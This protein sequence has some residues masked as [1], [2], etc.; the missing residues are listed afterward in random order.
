MDY[1]QYIGVTG[2]MSRGEIITLLDQIPTDFGINNDN[3]I[4]KI[5]IGMLVSGKT[6]QGIPNKWPN[7]Y[8][9]PDV[10]PS[11]FVD[12]PRV[13][14]LVHFNTKETAPHLIMNELCKIEDAAGPHFHGF[15]LNM[16]WPKRSMIK[17]WFLQNSHRH[18]KVIVLQ[19]G[20]KA[21]A[22]F[23]HRPAEIAKRIKDYEGVIDYVLLD[24]SGGL[25]LP[26]DPNFII[27]CLEE[28]SKIGLFTVEVGVAGG[29]SSETVEAKL[30]PIVK[31]FPNIS[32]DAEGRLRT[33]EDNL[34]TEEAVKYILDSDALF[35]KYEL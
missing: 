19:V 5:M 9:T 32:I 35:R 31:A 16:V 34:N 33:K 26:L 12:D 6:I 7:R 18:E 10:I 11:I 4:R 21:M 3:R 23:N 1:K 20:D 8:P 24:T 22:Q 29:L 30:T 25:G 27:E 28:I 15:Q 14:N 2:F 13:I 17:N